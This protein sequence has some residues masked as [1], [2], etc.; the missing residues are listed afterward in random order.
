MA[1]PKRTARP[2]AAARSLADHLR[3]DG[4]VSYVVQ[5]TLSC[6]HTV[7]WRR[8]SATK[9]T[10]ERENTFPAFTEK[11]GTRVEVE[12]TLFTGHLPVE[13]GRADHALGEERAFPSTAI[14]SRAFPASPSQELWHS[15]SPP[16]LLSWQCGSGSESG[17]FEVG[18]PSPQGA[19][20]DWILAQCH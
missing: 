13:R 7:S 4:H 14:P 18:P 1:A 15:P 17:T 2:P 3:A 5:H 12:P 6:Y 20:R 8:G 10:L 9:K 11:T 19:A 16:V